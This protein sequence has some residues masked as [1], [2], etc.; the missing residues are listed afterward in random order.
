MNI[1]PPYETNR[2]SYA[3]VFAIELVFLS[4]QTQSYIK[5]N[6]LKLVRYRFL[7]NIDLFNTSK[8]NERNKNKNKINKNERNKKKINN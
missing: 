8:N 4:R 2:R 6:F 3:Y 7:S 5:R 1:V